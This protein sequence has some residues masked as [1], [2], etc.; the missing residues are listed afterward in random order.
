MKEIREVALEEMEKMVLWKK[1]DKRPRRQ[2]VSWGVSYKEK[3]KR[4]TRIT[5][6]KYLT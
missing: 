2:W 3:V 4:A 6:K 5:E 1:V